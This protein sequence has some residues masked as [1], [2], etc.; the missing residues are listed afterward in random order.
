LTL[1]TDARPYTRCLV[2]QALIV[3]KKP[4]ERRWID[5]LPELDSDDI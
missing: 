1:P 4:I 5:A 2:W 3:G